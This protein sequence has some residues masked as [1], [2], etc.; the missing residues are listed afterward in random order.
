MPT[1]KSEDFKISAVNYYLDSNK[2]QEEVCNIFKCSVRSLMRWVE[3]YENEDSIKRHNREPI[4]YKVKKEYVK[5]ALDEMKKNK[6]ITIEVLLSKLKDKFKDLELTR[7]HLADIIKDNNV[8]LKLTHI[9]HEPNKRFGKDININEKLKEFYKEI[10][11]HNI[12]DI[13]CIDETSINALQKRH[14]CYNDVGKRCVITTQSQEVF[15]KYTAIFAIGYNGVLGWT[16]Y[17]KS[18]IDSIR[19][20]K[21]LEDNITSKY[22]NKAIILDNASAHRNEIIKNLVNKDNKLIYSCPYQ[23]FTNAIEH[24]FSIL[25]SR[26][27]KLE[28]LTYNELKLNIGK[29]IKDIPNET[30]KNLLIG[31]YKRDVL[32]VK[33]SSRKLSKKSKT[34]KE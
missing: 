5:F 27:Q 18:G 3:R 33:K 19:L 28:G 9:R 4:S 30:Y 26:L 2:T 11:K 32:Y 13:I 16:L 22:K 34:Y 24:Y 29:V 10:K 8:S 20:K 6:T 1:H 7:R 17:E 31:S 15:K 14:H 23:H 12:K 21:F 25:K